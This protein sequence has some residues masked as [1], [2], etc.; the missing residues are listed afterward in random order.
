M[1]RTTLLT[2]LATSPALL[3]TQGVWTKEAI[4]FRPAEGVAMT[5]TF[6]NTMQYDLVEMQVL[7]NGEENA[8]MPEVDMQMET[9]STVTVTDTYGKVDMGRPQNLSRSFDEVRLDFTMEMSAEGGL[10]G[11]AAET[12]S[13]SGSSPLE[14]REVNFAWDADG[15]DYEVSW[16]DSEEGGESHL[17]RDLSEDM[18]VRGLLPGKALEIDESYEIPLSTLVDVLAPGGDLKLDLGEEARGSALEGADPQMMSNIRKMFGDLLEGEATGTLRSVEEVDGARIA[19]IGLAIDVETVNDMTETMMEVM[20]EQ[21]QPG[22]EM[23]L[24]RAEMA[25]ALEATGELRW[26]LTAGHVHSMQIEGDSNTAMEMEISIDL[27]GQSMALEMSM[28]MSGSMESVLE[29]R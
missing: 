19:L 9:I 2:L 1:N 5:K 14:G 4:S 8:M 24:D 29:T 3:A 25:F 6:Q 26:N 28:E 16:G 22:M 15:E 13:G 12:P 27:G 11:G 20:E 10:G 23:N 17:L 21:A 18:D 7:M